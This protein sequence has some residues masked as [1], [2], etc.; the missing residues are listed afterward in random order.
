MI[1]DGE[2]AVPSLWSI[3]NKKTLG[4]NSA[5]SGLLL[6]KIWNECGDCVAAHV[7]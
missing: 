2:K 7:Q 6:I 3:F 5:M 4:I 1:R